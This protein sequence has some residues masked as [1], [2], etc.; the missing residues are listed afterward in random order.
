MIANNDNVHC[1]KQ[2]GREFRN[3]EAS[4]EKDL[5]TN[6]LEEMGACSNQDKK[7]RFRI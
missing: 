3:P 6:V 1:L 4:K 5:R 7:G 2:Q